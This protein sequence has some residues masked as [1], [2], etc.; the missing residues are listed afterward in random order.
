MMLWS[1]LI[2]AGGSMKSLWDSQEAEAC[3]NPLELR[4]YTSRLLG[5]SDDLVLHGGG[6]TS[7][8]DTVTNIFGEAED[9]LYVKGS[10][11]DLKTIGIDGFAPTQ[12]LKLQ[13]L[14]M[15]NELSDIDMM[16]ELKTS[17]I[18]PK[19]P[20]PSVEAILHAIIPFKYVDHTHTD[21][22]V[23]ITN[24]QGGE[25]KIRQ[26][27]GD[28]MLVL[29]YVMPGFILAKQVYEATRD[30]DWSRYRGITLLHHGVFT[31]D[32][33]ARVSYEN[34]IR[35]VSEAEAYIDERVSFTPL[36][37]NL[38]GMDALEFARLRQQVSAVR[39]GPTVARFR[40][41]SIAAL[42]NVA[43]CGRRG[44]ITPDHVLHTKR[45]PMLMSGNHAADVAA[46]AEAYQAYFD[47]NNAD[48]LICLDRAPRWGIYPGKGVATFGLNGKRLRV[49][50]DIIDHTNKAIQWGE[51]MGGWQ[52]LPAKDIFDLEYWELEQAKLKGQKAAGGLEGKVAVVTGASSGIGK[53]T[54]LLL[55]EQGVCV[56]GVDIAASVAK[57]SASPLYKGFIADLTDTEAVRNSLAAAVLHFGGI[58]ILVSNAGSFPASSF[59]E[60]TND[61]QWRTALGLNLDS[62]FKVLREAIPYLKVGI[63]PAVVINASKN[64]LAPGP[65][66]GAYSVAKAA[67]TQLARVAAL[68]LA[69]DGVRVNVLHPDAV[70]DT[71]IWTDEVLQARADKYGMTVNEYKRRNLLSTEIGSCD[72][73]QAVLTLVDDSL[74]KSTGLQMTVDGGNERTI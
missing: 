49:C 32:D 23:T 60:D 33:D 28:D 7:V 17:Q 50:S 10:G 66:V 16:R 19:A 14:A 37:Q 24:T 6:N 63:D 36:D 43:D 35:F 42:D 30:L 5:Q 74:T 4:A 45:V 59:L 15:L 22:V 61:E 31:F 47:A 52:A 34:M 62:H 72:V 54:A 39:G 41:L 44:P 69:G 51:Q 8:K 57:V 13:K 67:L 12:L 38:A 68:E 26:L 55:L 21:A 46:F 27:Y 9:I 11:H 18:D 20:A 40:P 73:A 70:F 58:D 3:S 64:A 53:A 71:G 2:V 29:P 65:G 1:A 25:D 56:A 48:D